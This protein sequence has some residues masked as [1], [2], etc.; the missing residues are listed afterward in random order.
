MIDGALE[1]IISRADY[2]ILSYQLRFEEDTS[3]PA[4]ALLRLRRELNLLLKSDLNSTFSHS[5]FRKL[6][7][8]ELP[9]DPVLLRRVQQPAPGFIIH[10]DQLQPCQFS[11]GELFNLPVCFFGNGILLVEP[12]TCLL[13]SLGPIGIS[14]KAGRFRLESVLESCESD[15]SRTLWSGGKIEFTPRT[16]DLSQ[17]VE[18]SHRDTVTFELVTPARLLKNSRPL[19]RPSFAEVFPYVLRR[20]TGMLASWAELE[21]VFEV[22]DLLECSENLFESE[23][24]LAWQDWRPLRKREDVGGL[25][26]AVILSGPELKDL[27]PILKIGELFGI[28]K[29]AAFGAGRYRLI[30]VR[31][32]VGPVP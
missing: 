32:V 22:R 18:D 7:Q 15:A 13:E 26:G 12:F 1:K 4:Y 20:V 5:E 25:S 30:K 10:I 27:W 17:R 24:S 31:D 6:L 19:F 16:F 23:N 3:L 29:G 21:D 2:R 11:A 28:G 8:P 9:S 14:N